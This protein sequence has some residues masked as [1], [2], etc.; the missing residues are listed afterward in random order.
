MGNLLI[1][2]YED[3]RYNVK[4]DPNKMVIIIKM[5]DKNNSKKNI[6]ELFK[7]YKEEINIDPCI[8]INKNS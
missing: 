6:K 8:N 2:I 7:L 3:I 5:K 1:M 4:L